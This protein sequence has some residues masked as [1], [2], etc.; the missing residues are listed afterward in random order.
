MTGELGTRN[1]N[2]RSQYLAAQNDAALFDLHARTQIELTG[3]DRVKFLH[4][5][6]TND[7]KRLAPGEGC[8]AFVTNVKGRVVGHVFV[9]AA[10][11]ALWLETVPGAEAALLQ[12]FRRYLISEDVGLHGRSEQFAELLVSGPRTFERLRGL[13]IEAARLPVFGHAPAGTLPL[14][15]AA[16]P[17]LQAPALPDW[18]EPP[19]DRHP[20]VR[21][22]DWFGPPAVLL[23]V[24]RGQAA[25]L[26]RQLVETA[27]VVPAEDAVFE[28]VRIEACFP[29]YGRDVTEDNLAQ[30][31]G[32]TEQA[33]SFRKGCYLG[34]EPIARIDALGH[35]NRLLCGLHLEEGP[36]PDPGAAVRTWDTDAEI[37][38]VTSA[39]T[40]P[41]ADRPV[42]LAYV[43]SAA[44]TPG[45][46]VRVGEARSAA[47]VFCGDAF[48]HGKE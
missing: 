42:A 24:P 48:S 33:I 10:A 3:A 11:D 18:T 41:A 30:E 36:V 28:A 32:R 7:I 22:V 19:L 27:G 9:F 13:G 8:E 38:H 37:G 26:R 6:C 29:L 4:N 47:R 44:A 46:L 34:Q 25:E 43:Q 31:V 16:G 1:T 40:T 21:R 45:T 12:H 17:H 5:F 39:A 35:V 20:A 15:I 23:S 14:S 2:R